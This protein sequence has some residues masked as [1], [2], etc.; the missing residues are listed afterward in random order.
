MRWNVVAKIAVL[1]W[2]QCA[3]VKSLSLSCIFLVTVWQ[4]DL[5]TIYESPTI[6]TIITYPIWLMDECASIYFML[7]W[8]INSNSRVLKLQNCRH[9]NGS[10]SGVW[11]G[12]LCRWALQCQ[13]SWRNQSSVQGCSLGQKLHIPLPIVDNELIRRL[14]D[15]EFCTLLFPFYVFD[16][17]F[18]KALKGEF[19]YRQ[20]SFRLC[21]N[22]L[23]DPL[24]IY[25]MWTVVD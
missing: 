15:I 11:E 10:R 3:S 1:E 7:V 9:W 22:S 13:E 19:S 5:S 21:R 17:C 18:R 23:I 6:I 4:C 8:V 24:R 2:Y 20:V 14:Q 25:V 12:W 16:I